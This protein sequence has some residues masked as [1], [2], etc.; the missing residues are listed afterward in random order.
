MMTQAKFETRAPNWLP[1]PTEDIPASAEQ[2]PVVEE[3][4]LFPKGEV[5]SFYPRQGVGTMK[6][7]RGEELPFRIAEVDLVGPKGHPRYIAQGARVGYD[8][9]WSSHGM[10]LCRMKVY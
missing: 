5:V 1:L 7:A 2:M 6:N 9:G 3:N 10:R 8:V 4:D